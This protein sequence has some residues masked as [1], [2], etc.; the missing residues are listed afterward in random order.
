MRLLFR[1]CVALLGLVI[2]LILVAPLILYSWGLSNVD[3]RPQRPLRM[4]S[5]V[6]QTRIW[7]KAGG[8]EPAVVESMNPCGFF[9]R[10][11][12]D[13]HRAP[14]GEVAAYWIARSYLLEHRREPG[15]AAWHG[16]IAALT[17]WITRNWSTEEI[18]TAASQTVSDDPR[19]PLK[20]PKRQE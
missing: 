14:A 5:S 12:D 4:V 19:A 11:L 1:I 16:S 6:E 8:S 17:I 18:L 10:F 15:M 9:G 2:L 20:I 13:S 3:G 7:K